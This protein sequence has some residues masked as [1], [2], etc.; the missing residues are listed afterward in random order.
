[1]TPKS[2]LKL[3]PRFRPPFRNLLV[4]PNFRS[5]FEAEK[6]DQNLT[7]KSTPGIPFRAQSE[8]RFRL[9]WGR[10]KPLRKVPRGGPKA[11]SQPFARKRLRL[12]KG[13]G[14]LPCSGGVTDL[15]KLRCGQTGENNQSQ[16]A[17]P[18]QGFAF[19]YDMIETQTTRYAFESLDLG[20][21]WVVILR[22]QI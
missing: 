15:R 4:S 20:P 14:R 11:R 10:R 7:A 13:G 17:P 18:T 16:A 9:P 19:I 2:G 1:M 12:N 21:F 3:R 6:R 22:P 8:S 5:R